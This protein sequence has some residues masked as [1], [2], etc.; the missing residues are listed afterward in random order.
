MDGRIRNQEELCILPKV[1]QL[2]NS[3]ARIWTWG[4]HNDDTSDDNNSTYSINVLQ[5]VN[6]IMFGKGAYK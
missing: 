4:K 1:T 3:W 2:I 5:R 6:K